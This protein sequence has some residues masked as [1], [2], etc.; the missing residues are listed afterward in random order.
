[1]T[2]EERREIRHTIRRMWCWTMLLTVAI[3]AC[4]RRQ[5]FIELEWWWVPLIAVAVNAACWWLVIQAYW[6]KAPKNEAKKSEHEG[7]AGG[8]T[9]GLMGSA[10]RR[11]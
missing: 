1:M 4:V 6:G 3:A 9:A 11:V 8:G 5:K 10:G 7:K 2:R